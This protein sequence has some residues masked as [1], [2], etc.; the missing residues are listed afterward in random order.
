MQTVATD[1]GAIDNATFTEDPEIRRLEEELR[2]N[3]HR[4]NALEIVEVKERIAALRRARDLIDWEKGRNGRMQV[5]GDVR[6]AA[7]A[8]SVELANDIEKP[9][10]TA[11]RTVVG[12][13]AATMVAPAKSTKNSKV[14]RDATLSDSVE[15]RRRF[16]G[17]RWRL[18][19]RF[20]WRSCC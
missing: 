5:R 3:E 11:E 13:D 17:R 16:V 8:D 2:L 19:G 6:R 15:D 20:S 12:K 10:R 7:G 14:V 4:M 1:D 9:R 18:R